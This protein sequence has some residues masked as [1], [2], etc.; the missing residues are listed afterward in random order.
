MKAIIHIGMWKTGSTSIQAWLSK[1]RAALEAKGVYLRKG[2][3]I[4]G[5]TG[6]RAIKCA[7]Y[8]VAK[9]EMGVDEKTAWLGPQERKPDREF[10]YTEQAQ[11]LTRQLEEVSKKPVH[12][13]IPPSLS[14]RI[15]F[16]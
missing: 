10:A 4:S 11:L 14:T 7:I 16:K 13:S 6:R 5:G 9:D 8:Y 12:S 2:A 3:R 15:K 1:N